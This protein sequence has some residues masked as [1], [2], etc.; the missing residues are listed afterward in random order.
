MSFLKRLGSAFSVAGIGAIK[1]GWVGGVVY[2]AMQ[3]DKRSYEWQKRLP[4]HLNDLFFDRLWEDEGKSSM[5]LPKT[6]HILAI[7][8]QAELYNMILEH[9][10]TKQP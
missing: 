3:Q 7:K 5:S 6:E 8:R 2:E 10:C 9:Y 1:A 4:T